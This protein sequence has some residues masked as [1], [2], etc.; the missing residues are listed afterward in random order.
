MNSE[1]KLWFNKLMNACSDEQKQPKHRSVEEDKDED[2][3]GTL[4]HTHEN[5][6]R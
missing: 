4:E 6:R 1:G 3:F 5:T 2:K